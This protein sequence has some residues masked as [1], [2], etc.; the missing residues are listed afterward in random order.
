[1]DFLA[2]A[3]LDALIMPDEDRP[4]HYPLLDFYEDIHRANPQNLFDDCPEA[5]V[6]SRVVMA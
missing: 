4:L 3:K 2:I 6:A 5:I 1:M